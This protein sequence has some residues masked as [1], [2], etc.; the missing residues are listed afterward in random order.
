MAERDRRRSCVRRALSEQLGDVGRHPVVEIQMALVA[1]Q[2]H[3]G[4]R[5]ALGHG[6][7]PEHRVGG[8]RVLVTHRG[9]SDTT[10]MDELA[11]HGHAVGHA[12][13]RLA[14][15]ERVDEPVDLGE[16]GHPSV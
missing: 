16:V 5:E 3:R 9:R 4:G 15:D 2:Q 14:A 7:D 11:V 13:D 8:R 12:R 10:R 1:E 6:G